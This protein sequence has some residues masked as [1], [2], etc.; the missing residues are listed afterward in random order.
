[1]RFAVP[2]VLVMALLSAAVPASSQVSH[3]CPEKRS[4]SVS[5]TGTI[6]LDADLAIV[7]VGYKLYAPDAKAAYAKATEISNAIMSA[8]TGIGI[9]KTDIESSNQQLQHTPAYELQPNQADAAEREQR[10]FTISQSWTVRVMPEQAARALD[11]AV[12]AGANESGSIEWTVKDPGA[13]RAQ[14]DA[15]AVAA[16]R[17]TADVIARTAGVRIAQVISIAED[18]SGGGPRPLMRA[19]AMGKSFNF[20]GPE[21]EPL[22]INSRRIQVNAAV[23]AVF[24]IE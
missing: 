17:H 1:M 5:A 21:S 12:R 9:A 19:A 20:T 6:T 8:L 11:A 10:Q 15:K 4:I 24:A 7:Q 22:A 23:Q 2:T 16:A 3:N 13:A 18:Q 14:A